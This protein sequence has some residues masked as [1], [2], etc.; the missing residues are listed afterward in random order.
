MPQLGRTRTIR[1]LLPRH[2]H[3]PSQPRFPV[4][5][6]QDG[7][8]LFDAHTAHAGHWYLREMM[9]RQPRRRQAIL[10]G[11][12]NGGTDRLHEYAPHRRGDQGGQGDQYLDFVAHTLKPFID[13][14]YR[15]LPARQTTPMQGAG[16]MAA[17]LS[18]ISVIRSGSGDSPSGGGSDGEVWSSIA[19]G[20]SPTSM[21]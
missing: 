1:V 15:T 11:I 13:Q 17:S 14:Q 12:D 3:H 9:A 2:Y 5:Y 19:A 20:K 4:V 16:P 6:W 10:V 8:N 7:Q 21:T 18:R